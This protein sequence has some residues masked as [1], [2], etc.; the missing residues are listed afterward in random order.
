MT[1]ANA[2]SRALKNTCAVHQ[3]R[4]TTVTFGARATVKMPRLPPARPATIHGL[5]MPYVE[6]VRSLSLPKNGLAT[7]DNSEPT[8]VT[9]ASRP[10]AASMPTRSLTFNANETSSGARNSREV[11]V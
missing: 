6:D 8:L 7:I 9:S 1:A 11:P 2:A 4:R 3:P 10:G 5:R